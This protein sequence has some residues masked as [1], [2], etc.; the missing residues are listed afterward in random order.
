MNDEI[1]YT[2]YLKGNLALSKNGIWF[3]NGTPFTNP[4]IISLFHRSIVWDEAEKNYFVQ[5]GQGRATFT[6]EDTAYFVQELHDSSAPWSVTLLDGTTETLAAETLLVG[7]EG[8]IYCSVKGGLRARFLRN[9]HQQLLIHTISNDTLL[10]AG[11]RIK[12]PGA[13]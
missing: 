2:A 12:L 1:L 7:N 8:Q 9:V 11:Q 13:S 4:Q 5:I 10:V 6:C 3:Y